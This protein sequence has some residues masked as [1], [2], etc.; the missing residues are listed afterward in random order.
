MN[1]IRINEGSFSFRYEP[2]H[3][4]PAAIN[5]NFKFVSSPE[6]LM[7]IWVRRKD[8]R[9]FHE[10]FVVEIEDEQGLIRWYEET[11]LLSF[12]YPVMDY[13]MDEDVPID[14]LMC[15]AHVRS[16]SNQELPL[17]EVRRRKLVL[18]IAD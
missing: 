13:Y 9:L 11:T 15:V 2:D 18:L 12:D 8:V 1:I 10:P 14:E 5:S 4:K 6:M 17:W 16:N 3:A 7:Q